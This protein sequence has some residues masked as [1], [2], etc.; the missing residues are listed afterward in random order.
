MKL[1]NTCKYWEQS[2]QNREINNVGNC[3]AVVMYWEATDWVRNSEDDVS[4]Q[5]KEPYKHKL[6]FVQDGSDYAASLLTL[7]TF[8]CV[9]HEEKL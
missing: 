9:Q 7:P 2:K 1:C 6:A 3:N 5:L 8:G 4:L